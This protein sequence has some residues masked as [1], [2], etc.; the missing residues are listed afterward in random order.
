MVQGVEF[1]VIEGDASGTIS[2]ERRS[3]AVLVQRYSNLVNDP[4]VTLYANF[5]LF[6]F[7]SSNYDIYFC[8]SSVIGS[9]L[10]LDSLF[11]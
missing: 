2:Q 9:F 10:E 1:R 4:Q 11:V 6:A 7:Q 5:L 8:K 3:G